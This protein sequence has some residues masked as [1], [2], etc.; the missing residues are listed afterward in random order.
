MF[1]IICSGLLPLNRY[2]L[3][4]HCFHCIW[5]ARYVKNEPEPIA[6]HNDQCC[7]K[8]IR[9]ACDCWLKKDIRAL[10]HGKYGQMQ[11]SEIIRQQ[12]L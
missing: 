8:P 4:K 3:K 12:G 9:V 5:C 1:C 2:A 7:M 6:R 10:V 11:R